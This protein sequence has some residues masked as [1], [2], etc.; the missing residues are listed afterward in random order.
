[1][2]PTTYTVTVV[3]EDDKGEIWA[4]EEDPNNPIVSGSQIEVYGLKDLT[5]EIWLNSSCSISAMVEM[6]DFIEDMGWNVRYDEDEFIF[7]LEDI[8]SNITVTFEF[9]DV[10]LNELLINN[11]AVLNDNYSEDSQ[12]DVAAALAEELALRGWFVNPNDI[13]VSD[14]DTTLLILTDMAHLISASAD[15]MIWKMENQT[16]SKV[17]SCLMNMM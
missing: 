6:Y 7:P 3:Y 4:P 5:L 8:R 1:M 16:S 11:Y 10:D 13:L 15:Y 2:D 9:N 12:D 17:I 14:I